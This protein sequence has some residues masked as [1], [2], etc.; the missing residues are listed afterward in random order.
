MS[1]LK[2]KYAKFK[3][4]CSEVRD[5]RDEYTRMSLEFRCHDKNPINEKENEPIC[6]LYKLGLPCVDGF[7]KYNDWNSGFMSVYDNFMKAKKER[8]IA[9]VNLFL[10][11]GSVQEFREYRRLKKIAD[12]KYDEAVDAYEKYEVA[13]SKIS[14]IYE[15][16][17]PHVEP[18][19]WGTAK[20]PCEVSYEDHSDL[21]PFVLD[22]NIAFAGTP[23][24]FHCPYYRR[25]VPC[26]NICMHREANN[27]YFDI[28]TEFARKRQE[29][30]RAVADV[31]A[32]RAA[33]WKRGNSK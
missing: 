5:K 32:A 29:Y 10:L 6:G 13:H 11:K 3:Q 4:A 14:R 20:Y 22:Y 33:I 16:S 31:K 24:V 27:N 26:Q 23:T 25:D 9:F 1:K 30:E 21:D 17:K 2:E 28:S 19:G 12:A 7:C 18:C 15:M 8:R